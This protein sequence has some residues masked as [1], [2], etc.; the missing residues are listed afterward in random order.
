MYEL[1]TLI[2]VHEWTWDKTAQTS[3]SSVLILEDQEVH[4]HPGYSSGTAAV[5][6]NKP[7]V[8]GSVY[9]WEIKVLTPLYGTDVVSDVT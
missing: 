9:Y 7:F 5:R 6:G 2:A 3:S 1:Q 8:G 4:F